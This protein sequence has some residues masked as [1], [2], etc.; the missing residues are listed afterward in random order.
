MFYKTSCIFNNIIFIIGSDFPKIQHWAA[1]KRGFPQWESWGI[2]FWW[3]LYHR[4]SLG[5]VL[6]WKEFFPTNYLI[7]SDYYGPKLLLL[8]A[9]YSSLVRRPYS[10]GQDVPILQLWL[11]GFLLSTLVYLLHSVWFRFVLWLQSYR[12]CLGLLHSFTH[13]LYMRTLHY[14]LHIILN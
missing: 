13:V 14:P 1:W 6:A 9:V 5:K 12:M 8:Q 2:F 11:Q 7:L 3:S 4:A 10:Y